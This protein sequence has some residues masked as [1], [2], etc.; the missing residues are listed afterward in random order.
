[1]AELTGLPDFSMIRSTPDVAVVGPFGNGSYSVLPSELILAANG[2]GTPKFEL[3]LVKRVEDFSA[4]GQYAEL[5]FSLIGSYQLDA[6]LTVAR[7][8][9]SGATVKPAEIGGGFG[10]L[11]ETGS[12]V[13]LPPELLTPVALRWWSSDLARWTTRISADAG[14]LLKGALQGD[15]SLLLGARVDVFVNGVAPRL[16]VYAE[17]DPVALLSA[18]IGARANRA[19]AVSDVLAFFATPAGSLPLTLTTLPPGCEAI[20]AQILTDRVVAEYGA[21]IPAPNLADPP[22]VQFK[23]AAEIDTGITRWDLAEPAAVWR[24][25]VFTLDPIGSVKALNDPAVLAA[26]VK[27]V[28]V[29]AL[30]IGFHQ[31]D[32]TA[33]LPP[34]RVGIA[35]VGARLSVP[36]NPPARTFSVEE[37]VLFTPP[38]DEGSCRF[39]LG[40]TETTQYDVTCFAVIAANDF[41]QQYESAATSHTEPWVQL[42]AGDFPLIFSHISASAQLLRLANVH[43]TQRYQIGTRQVQ[44]DFTLTLDGASEVTVAAPSQAS[45]LAIALEALPLDGAPAVALPTAGPGRIA[46]DVNSFAG[47]GPHS[48]LIHATVNQGDALFAEFA[49]ELIAA[50][51]NVRGAMFALTS[52]QPRASWSY[53]AMSPFHS[54]YCYRTAATADATPGPWSP[55]RLPGAVLELAPAASITLLTV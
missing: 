29:P 33:T 48:V 28:T 34:S 18:L 13:Q 43:G 39:T 47:Y 4:S 22:Y 16:A 54:G 6:G 52:D 53:F 40:A 8:S 17:F 38:D 41:A 25:W 31:V 51:S 3:S 45:E 21:L 44:Q 30:N 37:T 26:V 20:L 32:F 9:D 23:T 15:S 50:T 24:P 1:M 12:S 11:Y 2:D 7:A 36:P 10:R 14:E 27:N 5:D 42:G 55:A 19:M 49:P 46:L 35:A